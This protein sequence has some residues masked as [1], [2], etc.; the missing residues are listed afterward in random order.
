MF[1]LDAFEAQKC[2]KSPELGS[3]KNSEDFMVPYQKFE[4]DSMLTLSKNLN[5]THT[6]FLAKSGDIT[7]NDTITKLNC[8][9]TSKSR[10]PQK[11]KCIRRK[12]I[13]CWQ[14]KIK[15]SKL[16]TTEEKMKNAKTLKRGEKIMHISSLTKG[17]FSSSSSFYHLC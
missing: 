15:K 10:T 6:I 3:N 5:F 13:L 14:T 9:Q 17:L 8:S 7:E 4:T 16:A 2:E 1:D 12:I 11:E